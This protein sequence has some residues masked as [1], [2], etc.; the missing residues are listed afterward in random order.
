MD[1]LQKRRLL[2]AGIAD[3]QQA[4]RRDRMVTRL[5]AAVAIALGLAVFFT[6][7][8]RLTPEQRFGFFEATFTSP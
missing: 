2:A 4:A 1:Q 3:E 5:L 6:A 7:E 8:D